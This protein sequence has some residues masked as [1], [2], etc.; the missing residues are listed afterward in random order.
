MTFRDEFDI[1]SSFS[2]PIEITRARDQFLALQFDLATSDQPDTQ[3]INV[4]ELL[5]QVLPLDYAAVFIGDTRAPYI[6]D[7][8]SSEGLL[9]VL[10]KSDIEVSTLTGSFNAQLEIY[11]PSTSLSL[12]SE[13]EPALVINIQITVKNS[14]PSNTEQTAEETTDETQ[15]EEIESETTNVT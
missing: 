7:E 14:S 13:A 10:D 5:S 12:D 15:E 2:Q 8:S 11:V 9:I 1:E 6:K 4:S 3:A